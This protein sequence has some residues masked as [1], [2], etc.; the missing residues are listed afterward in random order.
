MEVV[1]DYDADDG[2]PLVRYESPDAPGGWRYIAHRDNI[3]GIPSE[4]PYARVIE[5]IFYNSVD[6]YQYEHGDGIKNPNSDFDYERD[7][8][9]LVSFA[10]K[11]PIE[12]FKRRDFFLELFRNGRGVSWWTTTVQT[13]VNRNGNYSVWLTHVVESRLSDGHVIRSDMR[14]IDEART[15]GI[16]ILWRLYAPDGPTFRWCFWKKWR[17]FRLAFGFSALNAGVMSLAVV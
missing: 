7:Y 17:Q 15:M 13:S 3:H 11:V 2:P 8:K 1:V 10:E 16:D 12:Q 14:N 9:A 6:M 4:I 5:A